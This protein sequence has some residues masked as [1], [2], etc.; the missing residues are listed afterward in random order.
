MDV[1]RRL[2]ARPPIA[3][4][5]MRENLNRAIAGA[6]LEECLNLEATH[7]VHLSATAGH[8]NAVRAFVEK[9]TPLFN[10]C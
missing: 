8:R 9:R 7:H 6:S 3:Y 2:A 10:G 5:Y 1:A 4:R